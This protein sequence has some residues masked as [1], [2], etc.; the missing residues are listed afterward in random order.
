MNLTTA[1]LDTFRRR[2]GGTFSTSELIREIYPGSFTDS[3]I[4]YHRRIL[5]HLNKLVRER[6]LVVADIKGK[7]E[8][9]FKLGFAHGEVVIQHRNRHIVI[10]NPPQFVTS[11]E[12]EE[13][14]GLAKR[15]KPESWMT[16]NNAIMIECEAFSSIPQLQQ[17]LLK[18]LP[19]VSD[20]I[21][22]NRFDTLQGNLQGFVEWLSAAAEDFGLHISLLLNV[23]RVTDWDVLAKALILRN[24]SITTV[25]SVTP[26]AL[27]AHERG[28]LQLLQAH[29]DSR[30]PISIKNHSLYPAPLFAGT[31]GVYTFTPDDYEHFCQYTRGTADGC[32]VGQMSID[33][34][35]RKCVEESIP[36]ARDTIIRCLH[37]FFDIEEQRRSRFKEYFHLLSLPTA[38]ATKEFLKTGRNYIRVRVPDDAL[39]MELMESIKQSTATFCHNQEIIFK[40]CGM[41]IR[42]R[43]GFTSIS[44]N[45]VNIDTLDE[46]RDWLRQQETLSRI[47]EGAHQLKFTAEGTVE[48]LL[49]SIRYVLNT[50]EFSLLALHF[51]CMQKNMKLTNF[52]GDSDGY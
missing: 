3:R 5:Y 16:K 29:I 12:R 47:H 10:A 50:T 42:F 14:E 11:I 20:V 44:E 15:F 49:R 51:P 8:K 22:L 31:A 52:L 35:L 33:I 46:R 38:R 34:D 25:L 43:V 27:M 40:S 28:I 32:V 41:P 23:E 7:G 18:I 19:F 39:A 2:P 37:S 48:E 4:K 36:K 6:V 21:A 45:S 9:V 26:K 17:R 24:S 1:I 30:L 13:H